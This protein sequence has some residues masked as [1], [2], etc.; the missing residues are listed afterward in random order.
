MCDQAAFV[1]Y[2]VHALCNAAAAR[3]LL[4]SAAPP[5]APSSSSSSAKEGGEAAAAAAA[6][7]TTALQANY[8]QAASAHL[9]TAEELLTAAVKAV[10][11]HVDTDARRQ[12]LEYLPPGTAIQ[13]LPSVTCHVRAR[14]EET[15]RAQERA[16]GQAAG[17]YQ[18]RVMPPIGT[19]TCAPAL[20]RALAQLAGL[21]LHPQR[22]SAP[23]P[24]T[25]EGLLRAAL[26]KL[27]GP[28]ALR[29]DRHVR[30]LILQY[31]FLL[32]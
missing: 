22:G 24:V 27:N 32:A 11:T 29:D 13:L 25:A 1:V 31:L 18:H 16:D 5:S 20:G 7:A 4:A 14:Q 28:Y 3:T 21:Y 19:E 6:V 26:D 10:S 2:Y 23:D 9:A 12:V 8:A 15:L 30:F 17:T